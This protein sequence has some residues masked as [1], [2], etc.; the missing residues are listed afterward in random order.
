MQI[1]RYRPVLVNWYT[2]LLPIAWLTGG[3]AVG[4]ATTFP[5]RNPP[6]GLA[7]SAEESHVGSLSPG[8]QVRTRPDVPRRRLVGS[9][10]RGFELLTFVPVR[11]MRFPAAS[12]MS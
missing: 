6:A 9:S 10:T 12:V 3:V 2:I 5:A 4:M 8:A 11:M 7:P 1:T